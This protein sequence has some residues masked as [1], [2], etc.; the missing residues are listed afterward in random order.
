MRLRAILAAS[1]VAVVGVIAPAGNGPSVQAAPNAGTVRAWNA[2]ALAAL[3]AAGQPPNVAVLHMAMVQGAVYDAVNS[4][5]GG[6]EAYLAGLS[7]APAAASLDAA[8]ATAAHSVLVGLR[9]PPVPGMPP[10]PILSAAVITNLD[11]LY[12]STL[13]SIPDGTAKTDGVAAGEAAASAMLEARTDD[14]RFVPFPLTPG[15]DPGEW[16]PI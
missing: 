9:F 1:A 16:R 3:G 7:P 5:D 6:H 12:R 4:I 11:S 2:N 13:A 14:G 15:T 8:A 10:A